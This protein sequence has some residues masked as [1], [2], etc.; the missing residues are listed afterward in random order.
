MQAPRPSR[1]RL[2]GPALTLLSFGL[3][4]HASP[5][6]EDPGAIAFLEFATK[7]DGRCQILSAGGK[8]R[9]LRNTHAEKAIKY[10]LVRMFVGVAQG[11]S[12]G[13]VPPG[14]EVVKL[15]CTRVDGRQ[16]EWIVERASFI[17]VTR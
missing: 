7:L 2:L 11:L 14:G 4:G 9:V 13:V 16:Q 17:A 5:L 6:A 12:V 8:L 1:R 10:R 15:G 3:N